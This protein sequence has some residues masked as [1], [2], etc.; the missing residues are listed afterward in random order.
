MA[1]QGTPLS[2]GQVTDPRQEKNVINLITSHKL[3]GAVGIPAN[4]SVHDNAYVGISGGSNLS[5][6]LMP[7]YAAGIRR[8]DIVIDVAGQKLTAEAKIYQRTD[9]RGGRM[10]LWL[11]P[12]QPAQGLLREIVRRHRADAPRKAKRPLPITILAVVPKLK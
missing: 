9:K 8:V 11:Y 12:L 5:E 2:T 7:Y 4:L 1:Q 6:I 3:L 10:Y